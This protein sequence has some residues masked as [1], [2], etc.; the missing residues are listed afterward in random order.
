MRRPQI[1][2]LG[3]G[4]AP[5][6]FHGFIPRYQRPNGTGPRHLESGNIHIQQ[7]DRLPFNSLDVPS[8]RW[9]NGRNVPV[10]FTSEDGEVVHTVPPLSA[11][12]PAFTKEPVDDSLCLTQP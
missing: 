2:V 11:N 8:D 5:S 4:K 9:D 7:L 6:T 10:V 12:N 3:M 1:G